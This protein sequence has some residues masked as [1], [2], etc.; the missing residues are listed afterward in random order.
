MARRRTIQS[1]QLSTS[2]AKQSYTRQ[3]RNFTRRTNGHK[4]FLITSLEDGAFPHPCFPTEDQFFFSSSEQQ[5][6]PTQRSGFFDH[7]L[8]PTGRWTV[9]TDQS[10]HGIIFRHYV[11][12]FQDRGHAF[13]YA[14]VRAQR[15]QEHFHRKVAKRRNIRQKP[16]DGSRK[17]LR[18]PKAAGSRCEALDA[19][20]FAELRMS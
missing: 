16:Q 10:D 11:N 12:R 4:S 9:G 19:I 7:I 2:L 5:S 6:L 1:R 17:E 20:S 18:P 13:I 8:S 14:R 3:G 15:P